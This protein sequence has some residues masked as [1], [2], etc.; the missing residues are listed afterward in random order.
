[1][2]FGGAKLR[3][4]W[5][6]GGVGLG[7]RGDVTVGD[8]WGQRDDHAPPPPHPICLSVGGIKGGYVCI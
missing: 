4:E 8:G 7:L 6:G 2:N 3:G 5:K 1:M